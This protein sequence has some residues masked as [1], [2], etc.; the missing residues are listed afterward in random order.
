[1]HVLIARLSSMG[2]LVQT[3]PALTDAAKA[4]PDIR[5]DWVV[6]ESFSQVPAWHPSV[7]RVI[8]SAFRRWNKNWLRAFRGGEP[9]EF[10]R[11]LRLRKYDLIVDVQGEFKSGLAARLARGP[12]HGYDGRAAHEW[13]AQLL[14]QKKYFVPKGIH[15]IQ[16]MRTLLSQALAYEYD[17]NDVNYG[18]EGSRLD[19]SP[20]E[21][22]DPYLVFVHS[23]S[24]TSKVW[25][26]S[27]WQMLAGKAISGGFAVVLPWGDE[28]ERLRSE[29][30]A[31][32][33]AGVVVLPQLSISQ[34]AAIIARA[35]AT[36]GLDTGLS[37]IAAAFDIPSVT[38]Y[39]ATDPLLVGATGKHQLHLASEF[40][41]VKCHET[42]CTYEGQAAFKPACFVEMTP[43]RVWHALQTLLT[44]GNEGASTEP[45]KILAET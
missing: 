1:M 25:P 33:R 31:A 30:I 13:G 37:H 9:Q 17:A 10:L 23:T 41:C 40:E 5:F 26:E 21:L 22:A 12:R 24:W 38:L 8:P 14:Y 20:I 44:S 2:D 11:E 7:D 42:E 28:A 16:R 36:V 35:R 39:G 27:Y 15:S 34:K 6:D 3:L 32:G 45:I 18:V 19:A 43:E 4:I 29:R